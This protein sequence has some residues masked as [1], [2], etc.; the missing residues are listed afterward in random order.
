MSPCAG[1]CD[2]NGEVVNDD[3]LGPYRR[4]WKDR[5]LREGRIMAASPEGECAECRAERARRH[6]VLTD[7]DVLAPELH[8]DPYS[9]APALYT[10]GVPRYF[11]T[12]L[13]AREYAKQK[14]VQLSWCY[15]RDVP[16]HPEDHDLPPDKISLT[17]FAS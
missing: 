8:R 3:V 10:F 13:R 4:T 17:P 14:K 1:K 6:R 7:A 11:A 15:A 9:S 2:C 12:N 5:F 16:L